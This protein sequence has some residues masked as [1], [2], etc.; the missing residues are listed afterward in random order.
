MLCLAR[1][2]PARERLGLDVARVPDELDQGRLEPVED[3][4]H[5]RRLHAGLEVV[6]EHVV[7][8]VGGWE[9]RE[10]AQLQLEDAVEPGAEGGVVGRGAGCDPGVVGLC[11][12]VGDLGCEL[13][14]HAGRLVPVAPR[15]P[16][17]ACVQ[18]VVRQ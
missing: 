13:G 8:V 11:G 14:R 15:D 1:E 16:D 7:R 2:R 17:E 4:A 18:V 10:V 9:A 6:Q 3:R 5:L 12:G